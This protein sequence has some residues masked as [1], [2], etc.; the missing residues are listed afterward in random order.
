VRYTNGRWGDTDLYY[1][2]RF[3]DFD[4]DH[5]GTDVDE[6]RGGTN[7]AV[8]LRHTVQL[9]AP[10]R[11][12][13]VEYRYDRDDADQDGGEVFDYDGHLARLTLGCA[14]PAHLQALA[15]YAYKREIYDSEDRR[16]NEHYFTVEL[17][18][19]FGEYFTLVGSYRGTVNDSNEE[20][21]EYDR[22]IVGVVLEVAY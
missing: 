10:A 19:P 11:F 18:R 6:V 14:L 7:N 4:G 2:F 12:A 3:R 8:G 16:D 13:S 22:H 5:F 1:R 15:G 9:G 20:L 17:Q 21:F